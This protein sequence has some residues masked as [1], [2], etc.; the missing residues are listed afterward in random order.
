MTTVYDISNVN[1]DINHKYDHIRNDKLIA[2]VSLMVSCMCA[3]DEREVDELLK[4]GRRLLRDEINRLLSTNITFITTA[5]FHELA[6][7]LHLFNTLK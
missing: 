7:L 1:T 4:Q 6:K 3:C 2:E 5:Y